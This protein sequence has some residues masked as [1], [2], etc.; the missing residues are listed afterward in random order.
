MS[1]QSRVHREAC[2]S[3]GKFLKRMLSECGA[4]RLFG[5]D[6]TLHIC[7]ARN[8]SGELI[9]QG[10]SPESV[11]IIWVCV[12]CMKVH[13]WDLLGDNAAEVLRE[14]QAPGFSIQPDLT[15]LNRAGRCTA[16][17]EFHAY[18]ENPKYKELA[19]QAGI[20][21]FVVDVERT[22]EEYQMGLHNPLRGMW[23]AAGEPDYHWADKGSYGQVEDA[24]VRGGSA[25]KFCA[26]PDDEG[27]LADTVFHAAGR[28]RGV[29]MPSTSRYLVASWSNLTC[30]SQQ[31]WMEREFII[32]HSTVSGL[33]P[34][35]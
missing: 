26:I 7:P 14:K 16:W 27:N 25:S 32:S 9:C 28:S 8:I 11:P 5:I 15:V 24:A 29:P 20:P 3:W 34:P 4:C 17:V 31:R 23:G 18:H 19:A 22:L 33:V 35:G 30:D 6:D 10:W 21:L 13:K 1:G 2:L 12:Q